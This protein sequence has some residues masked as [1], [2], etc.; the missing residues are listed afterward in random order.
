MKP[1]VLM[2]CYGNGKW[3][4]L[5]WKIVSQVLKKVNHAPKTCPSHFTLR[6]LPR[7]N[8]NL[9]QY[10]DLYANDHSSFIYNSYKL[11]LT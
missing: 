8:E 4:C 9:G 5:L 7:N 6:D 11:E 1:R 10:E 2:H 3:Y